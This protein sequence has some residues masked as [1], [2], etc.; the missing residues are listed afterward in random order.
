MSQPLASPTELI[1]LSYD[2]NFLLECDATILSCQIIK[3]ASRCNGDTKNDSSNKNNELQEDQH[4]LVELQ[5]DRTVM[6]PQGGGQPTDIGVMEVM[7]IRT[8]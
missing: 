1:H 3:T 5:L 7:M 2:G 6:H 8:R 4:N